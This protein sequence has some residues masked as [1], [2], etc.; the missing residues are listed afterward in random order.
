LYQ[1]CKLCLELPELFREVLKEHF[2]N[3]S[4]IQPAPAM[5]ASLDTA[6]EKGSKLMLLMNANN[7]DAGKM[8]DPPHTTASSGWRSEHL[9]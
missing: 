2:N 5:S 8:F 4:I 7:E 6:V 3:L 1:D 9:K